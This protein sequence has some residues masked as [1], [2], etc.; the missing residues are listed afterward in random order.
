MGVTENELYEGQQGAGDQ[1]IM[2]GFA[3]NETPEF[4]PAPVSYAHRILRRA[5]G[6]RKSKEIPWLRPDSKSQVSVRYEGYKAV[7][8]DSVVVSHQHDPDVA[9]AEIRNTIVEEIV[10]PAFEN[11]GLLN[12]DTKFYINPTGRFV[13]G[14]PHGDTGLTGRKTIVD[15]YGGMARHGGGAF[16]GKDPSKVDSSATYMARYVAKNI[17]AAG[18]A[19]RVEVQFAYA[20]GVPFPVS[21]MI[22][23][24][25][26][27][28]TED[29]KIVTAIQDLFDLSPAGIEKAL[30]LRRPIYRQTTNYGHFGRDGFSWER[31]DKI[32]ALRSA[33]VRN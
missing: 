23:S 22:D 10:R 20:I 19:D 26:T 2:F 5:A 8:I 7:G 11:T 21:V 9:V 31:T 4:M 3:C 28:I 15:T 24:F 27:G 25:G 6:L 16:S 18:I 12:K 13:I 32:E 17:V 33:L 14:G 1:G 30:D 29:E